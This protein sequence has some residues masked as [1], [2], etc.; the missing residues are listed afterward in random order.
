[1]NIFVKDVKLSEL[2]NSIANVMKFKWSRNDDV[3]PPTY[4]L[5]VDRKAADAAD[6]Q[7]TLAKAKYEELWQKRRNEWIDAIMDFSSMSPAELE[8]LRDSDPIAYMERRRGSV[9][10]IRALFMEVPETEERYASGQ[11]FR[12]SADKLSAATKNLLFSAGNEVWKY[13]QTINFVPCP[14]GE[15]TGYGDILTP[16]DTLILRTVGQIRRAS[17][18]T[19]VGGQ[20][21]RRIPGISIS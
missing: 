17:H 15:P 14:S 9:Q 12:I 2:M 1:M 7:M 19:V 20:Q 16:E 18:Q 6:A 3:T 8:S 4:R 5:M 11:S 21:T 10:A 13:L